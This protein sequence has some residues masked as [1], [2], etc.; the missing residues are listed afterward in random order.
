MKFLLKTWLMIISKFI[1][2]QGFNLFKKTLFWKKHRRKGRATLIFLGL[3]HT[4]MNF[5]KVKKFQLVSVNVFWVSEYWYQHPPFGQ[6]HYSKRQKSK[7]FFFFSG[8]LLLTITPLLFSKSTTDKYGSGL[9]IPLNFLWQLSCY[10]QYSTI[11]FII[12]REFSMFD[13]IWLLPQTK[14]NVIISNKHGIY[15]LPHKLP[16]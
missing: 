8:I 13:Q 14:Q 2:S 12:F 4:E 15:E 9:V 10:D 1:K 16:T 3:T 5:I 11:I 6:D 7:T